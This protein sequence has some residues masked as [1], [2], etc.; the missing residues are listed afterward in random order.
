[1]RAL[2]AFCWHRDDPSAQILRR[3]LTALLR[4][5]AAAHAA[6]PAAYVATL[7]TRLSALRR[8]VTVE[9]A[10]AAQCAISVGACDTTALQLAELG[11]LADPD[12]PVSVVPRLRLARLCR[13]ATKEDGPAW[14][15]G[16]T[17]VPIAASL[18]PTHGGSGS[19]STNANS[20]NNSAHAN[21]TNSRSRP[22]NGQ[23]QQ[24]QQQQPPAGRF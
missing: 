6:G 23:Q 24:P 7:S 4:E 12:L 13:P 18:L 1:L 21:G 17:P 2:P 11:L 19:G 5:L 22:R 8:H 20:S 15:N 14:V 16:S 3:A 10:A 9:Q